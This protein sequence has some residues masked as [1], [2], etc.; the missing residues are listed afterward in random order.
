M[1]KMVKWASF[2]L[3]VCT[4]T[5]NQRFTGEAPAG[6]GKGVKWEGAIL[7]QELYDAEARNTRFIPVVF[8]SPDTDHIPIILRS[9]TYYDV[10][11]DKGYEAL[12]RHLTG[13]PEITKPELGKLKPMPALKSTQ[14]KVSSRT[15]SSSDS[16]SFSLFHEEVKN[17]RC[18]VIMPFGKMGTPEYSRNWKIY[19]LMLKPVVEACGYKSIRADELEHMGNI[20]RDIIELLHE[21]D[22]VVADLSGHNVNVFYELGVRHALHRAGTVPVIREGE[23]LP[24]DIANYR[25]IFYSSE[26]DG[27]EQFK[28]E[29]TRRI[30]AFERLRGDT[31]DNPVHDILGDKLCIPNLSDF[32]TLKEHKKRL[33]EKEAE[34]QKTAQK[35]ESLQQQHQ[36]LIEEKQAVIHEKTELEERIKDSVLLKTHNEKLKENEALMKDIETLRGENWEAKNKVE[37]ITKEKTE[38]DNRIKELAKE[39]ARL[40]QF[41]PKPVGTFTNSLNMT[42]VYISPGTFMR[43]SSRSEGLISSL[44][45]TVA[46]RKD[47]TLSAVTLTQGFYM[48]TTQVT[49]AQWKAVM[50]NNPS[51]FKDCGDDCPVENVSWNDAQ[52]FIKRL[53]E[54]EGKPYRLPT[55]GEWEYACRAGSTSQ[56]CFGDD[57]SLLSEYAWYINNSDNRTHPVGTKKP[58]AWGLYDMHG[59]V[60]EWVQDWY[61]NYPSGSVTDPVG[62]ERGGDRVDRG[63]SWDAAYCRSGHLQLARPPLPLA[64]LSP[65]FEVLIFLFLHFYTFTSMAGQK[66]SVTRTT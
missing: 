51:G 15:V 63:G 6:Q 56:F 35:I 47:E 17:K 46:G 59:N 34:L 11:T 14:T 41:Q 39:I 38:L 26:L 16:A 30:E 40:N 53:N 48:Q 8:S 42:F 45:A 44:I 31:S 20:T 4:A 65:C 7:T 29:L 60:W 27:P 54:K 1:L 64:W 10:S 12:Y 21:S 62:P 24:F 49:Q 19:D 66:V 57:E 52:E 61:G 3:V 36:S 18:F 5:Y 28:K 9:Q 13:Q 25:A 22:L 33:G 43:V 32:V 37:I 55:E 50:G 2:V 23:I 58:N